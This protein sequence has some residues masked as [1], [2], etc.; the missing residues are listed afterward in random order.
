M[1]V[2]LHAL[3][4]NGMGLTLRTQV[5]AVHYLAGDL[6]GVGA[7][8]CEIGDLLEKLY[9]AVVGIVDKFFC[10]YLLRESILIDSG[11]NA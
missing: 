5:V 4:Y 11:K 6:A 3:L 1:P 7:V 8:D 10:C 2:S 9:P